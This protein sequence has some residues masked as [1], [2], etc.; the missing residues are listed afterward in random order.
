MASAS[1]PTAAYNAQ[2]GVVAKGSYDP[3]VVDWVRQAAAATGADPVAL[4]ATSL[5]ESGAQRGRIGDKGTSFGPFQHHIH[6]ALGNHP[7]A[8]ANTYPAVLERAQQFAR[9]KVQHGKGAAAVQK[10][11][12]QVL[13]A[14]GVDGLMARA[15]AILGD[16]TS[17]VKEKKAAVATLT[18]DAPEPAVNGDAADVGD[19]ILQHMIEA[20]AHVAKLPGSASISDE[21]PAGSSIVQQMLKANADLAGTPMPFALPVPPPPGR[22]TTTARPVALPSDSTPHTPGVK[23]AA[24]G[25]WGGSLALANTM[26]GIGAA[27]GLKVM[28]AKRERMHTSSG[29]VSDHW[30]G[31]KSSYAYD[32]SNGSNPTPQMDATALQIANALGAGAQWRKQGSAGVLNVTKGGYRYQML[33]RT[34]VGGNHFNH[35]HI[36]VRRV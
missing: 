16:P 25:G 19:L 33:Y 5:Q 17:T 8:W 21:L 35:V 34:K 23:L 13:Y 15:A 31:S 18:P 26:K 28:S 7:P 20:N 36:G 11:L 27:N 24:G 2:N 14:R 1:S 29:G 22:T 32:L 30:T 3:Q 12:D 9:Y 6:G 10:P 4:L